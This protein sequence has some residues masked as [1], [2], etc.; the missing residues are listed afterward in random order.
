MTPRAQQRSA[1]RNRFRRNAV[2]PA[3]T[4]VA[5]SAAGAA[6]RPAVAVHINE[7]SLR[8]FGAHAAP[9]IAAAMERELERLIVRGLPPR[10]RRRGAVDALSARMRL[11]SLRDAT[12]IGEELARAVLAAQREDRA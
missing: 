6:A 8:G 3:A 5:A 2:A 7:F 12:A 9:R 11:R 10:W 4:P 1:W